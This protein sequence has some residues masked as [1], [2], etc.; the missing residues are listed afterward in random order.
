MTFNWIKS[1]FTH[2]SMIII[3]IISILG[4]FLIEKTKTLAPD[5]AYS[6]KVQ[7]AQI[8]KESMEAIRDY[9]IENGPQINKVADPNLTG[10]IGEEWTPLTTTLGNLSAKRTATNP[11]FAALL[12][13]MF[14]KAGVKR[15]DVIAIGASGSFPSLILATLSAAGALGLK[16]ITI[17]A[18]GSSVWGGNIPELT[19]LDMENI[20]YQQ[21]LLNYRT[22]ASS[23]GAG[24]DIGEGLTE[25]GKDLILSAIQRNQIPLIKETTLEE[26]IQK[27]LKIYYEDAKGDKIKLFV[28]IGG[29]SANFGECMVAL[30]ITPGLN[31]NLEICHKPNRGII[32][33]MAE[34][35]I[36]IIHLLDIRSL[37][38]KNGLPIDP[39]P[40]PEIGKG[41]IYFQTKYSRTIII[42]TLGIIIAFLLIFWKIERRKK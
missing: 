33:E 22:V 38:I 36:P 1:K 6:T 14:I 17:C 23:I 21:G 3:L 2:L 41:D 15:G 42:I 18:H 9:R 30:K 24:E 11:D 16:P 19:W 12:I 39:I 31:K 28:N 7:A 8:M 13:D 27:R 4:L 32:Y 20:L 34:K 10:L 35:G 25:E 29:A 40:F 5:S 37:A 26:S